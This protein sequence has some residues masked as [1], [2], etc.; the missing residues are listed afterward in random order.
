[1]AEDIGEILRGSGVGFGK[2]ISGE[3]M[4]ISFDQ[5]LEI[6]AQMMVLTGIAEIPATLLSGA[7]LS[8]PLALLGLFAGLFYDPDHD[9]L[10]Y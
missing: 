6:F 8:I 1:M 2:F 7:M 4:K 10:G 3:P 5:R 9:Q